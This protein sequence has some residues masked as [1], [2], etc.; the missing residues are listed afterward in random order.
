MSLAWQEHDACRLSSHVCV[1]GSPCHDMHT[2]PRNLYA[3]HDLG[4]PGVS[5]VAGQENCDMLWKVISLFWLARRP[6]THVNFKAHWT[7]TTHTFLISFQVL[8]IPCGNLQV[9]FS[10]FFAPKRIFTP[11]PRLQRSLVNYAQR[12]PNGAHSNIQQ[13]DQY[14]F[15]DWFQTQVMSFL[16]RL[17][18]HTHAKSNGKW[19]A[20]FRISLCFQWFSGS[21]WLIWNIRPS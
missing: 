13:V 10:F 9:F 8:K 2:G 3:T 14:C 15:A 16:L 17:L 21:T 6:N 4:L 20:C 1:T 7:S 5:A 11:K 18:I 12:G 19:L